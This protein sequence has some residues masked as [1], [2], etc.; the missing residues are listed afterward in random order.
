MRKSG[1]TN[2]IGSLSA[3]KLAEFN[4]ALKMALGL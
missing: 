3:R 2:Y 4:S 1:L